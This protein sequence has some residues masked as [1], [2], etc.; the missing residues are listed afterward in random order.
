[1]RVSELDARVSTADD[2]SED[3]GSLKV[4]LADDNQVNQ[5]TAKTM[6]ERFGHEVSI[7]GNGLEAIEYYKQHEYDLIFMDVQ[8]PEMD[9][10]TA[11]AEIRKIER[12]TGRHIPI[13]AMTA[14]AMAGDKE[15]CLEAGMDSYVSKPIR[16]KELKQVISEVVNQFLKTP[17]PSE[18]STEEE[19]E[20]MSEILDEAELLEEID[21]DKEYLKTMLEMFERDA[22]E[23]LPKLK[24]AVQKGDCEMVLS[25]AHAVK[26]GVGNFFAKESFAIAAELETGGRNQSLDG[27]QELLTRLEQEIEKLIDKLKTMT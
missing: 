22:K 4:L 11:T 25:E 13:V 16:R 8:M 19:S 3:V 17:S 6:L 14:H 12:E 1:M 21:N 20:A 2:N 18:S 10:L 23:R 27:S 24:E 5:L 15:R 26:G 9:G 7:A